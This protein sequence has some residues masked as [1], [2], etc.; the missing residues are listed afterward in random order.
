[1]TTTARRCAGC[2]GPLPEAS[3]G[4]TEIKCE[5]CG[6]VN[7]L[8]RPQGGRPVTIQIET[9]TVARNGGGGRGCGLAVVLLVAVA[10]ASIGVVT[11]FLTNQAVSQVT[12][13]LGSMGIPVGDVTRAITAISPA[14]LGD[15]NTRGWKTLDVPEPPSG[16]EGF[17]PVRNLAWATSIARTWQPDASLTRIDVKRLPDTGVLNLAGTSEDEAGYRFLSSGQVAKWLAEASR[18]EAKPAV[19]YELMLTVSKG[20]VTGLATGGRPSKSDAPP[21]A[22]ADGLALGDLLPRAKR[23]KSFVPAAFYDG[24]MIFNEREG[25]VWYLTGRGQ[26]QT[27]PRVRA[28]DGAVYPYR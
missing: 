6:V 14:D 10:I 16:W 21:P 24:Y 5:F 11:T 9:R 23:A 12:G 15:A 20:R 18:G 26:L 1:M 7:E 22:S 19:A 8:A 17:D 13:A 4:I 27:L 25:W 3:P 2:A 28:K